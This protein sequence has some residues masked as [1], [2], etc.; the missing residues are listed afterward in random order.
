MTYLLAAMFVCYG[1]AYW[2]Y[3]AAD[4]SGDDFGAAFPALIM[5]ALS[6]ILTVIY[7][8]LVFWNHKFL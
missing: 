5:I 7:I 1:L 2:A 4:R 3:K 6:I 8:A